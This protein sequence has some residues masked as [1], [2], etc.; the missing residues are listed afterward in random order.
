MLEGYEKVYVT[1]Y[2]I[3]AY[4]ISQFLYYLKKL[5]HNGFNEHAINSY[6]STSKLHNMYNFKNI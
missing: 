5:M 6:K 4:Y 1:F 3:C 2:R